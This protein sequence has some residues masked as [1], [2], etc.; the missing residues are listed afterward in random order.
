MVLTTEPLLGVGAP[1]LKLRLNQF[2][3]F[4]AQLGWRPFIAY[5]LNH[6]TVVV[7][8][9]GRLTFRAQ[10]FKIEVQSQTGMLE[11]EWNIEALWRQNFCADF[12]AR[13]P[14]QSKGATAHERALIGGHL[15]GHGRRR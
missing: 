11:R 2:T 10:H 1:S 12:E 4:A 7:F 5:Q 9:F 6:Q 8:K 13:M 14:R 15:V 3:T